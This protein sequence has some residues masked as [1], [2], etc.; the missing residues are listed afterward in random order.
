MRGDL[1][2]GGDSRTLDSTEL[3]LYFQK[4]QKSQTYGLKARKLLNDGQDL[5]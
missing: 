2:L 4:D 5:N 1:G 3:I